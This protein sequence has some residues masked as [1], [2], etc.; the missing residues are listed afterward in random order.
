MMK[1]DPMP[2][3]VKAGTKLYAAHTPLQVPLH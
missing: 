2:I 3:I 1:G